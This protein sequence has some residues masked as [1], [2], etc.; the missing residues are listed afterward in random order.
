MRDSS[1]QSIVEDVNNIHVSPS[2]VTN[3]SIDT[4]EWSLGSML[5]FRKKLKRRQ[6]GHERRRDDDTST[7]SRST[8]SGSTKSIEGLL[9][10][11]V[12]FDK[13]SHRALESHG[14]KTAQELDTVSIRRPRKMVC[15]ADGRHNDLVP[16]IHY[17]EDKLQW[18]IENHIVMEDAATSNVVLTIHV[19]HAN[20]KV[21]VRNCH[22]VSIDIHGKIMKS[23]SIMDCSDLNVVFHSVIDSCNIV[24][25]L[26]IAA[27]T[28][29]VC[30]KFTMD[31]TK[32]ISL[33]L[34]IQSRD[35]SNIV[36][37]KSTQVSVFIPRGDGDDDYEQMKLTLPEKYV[38]QFSGG[39]FKSRASSA[40]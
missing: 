35:V 29:G 38:H 17:E 22:G 16:K 1:L 24:H 4:E 13:K 33:W 34:S 5:S 31:R 21:V 37:S 12:S 23:L 36:T 27:E 20:Q 8:R 26:E 19:S 7:A 11:K 9:R 25:S 39:M 6:G 2:T 32:G 18:T 15:Q 28:T 3:M 30:P 40:A 14:I 10:R